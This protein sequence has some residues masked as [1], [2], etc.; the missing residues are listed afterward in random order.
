MDKQVRRMSLISQEEETEKPEGQ[1]GLVTWQNKDDKMEK[2]KK[3]HTDCL[4]QVS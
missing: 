1:K 2:K 4:S 3:K